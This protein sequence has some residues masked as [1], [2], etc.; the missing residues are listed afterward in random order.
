[1]I[2]FLILLL[3][4]SSA[5]FLHRPRPA[6][7][8]GDDR[9]VA[10]ARSLGEAKAALIAWSIATLMAV[11]LALGLLRSD[12]SKRSQPRRPQA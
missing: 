5:M 10:T 8:A 9:H 6:L 7:S 12:L 2:V 3:L 4:G 1:M 11:L